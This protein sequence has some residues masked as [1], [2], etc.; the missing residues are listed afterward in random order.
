[1][2]FKY[3]QF[4]VDQLY[5]NE[6]IKNIIQIGYQGYQVIRENGLQ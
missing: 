4:I 1:M 6:V 2:N 5:L 3:M